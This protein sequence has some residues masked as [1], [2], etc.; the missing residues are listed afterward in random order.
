MRMNESKRQQKVARL[1]QKEI[2][3][4][5][6][7]DK[8]NVL[9]N[10]FVTVSDVLISPDLSL[11]RVYL[12]MLLLDE[13]KQKELIE[14]INNRKSEIRGIL[15]RRIGKQMRIVPDLVFF[16]DNLEEQALKIDSIIDSLDIPPADEDEEKESESEK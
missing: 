5:L 7:K 10:A 16:R 11:A 4:I 13:P 14:T 12:S 15:G 8:R 2:G 9:N 3:E 6:Q 1:I